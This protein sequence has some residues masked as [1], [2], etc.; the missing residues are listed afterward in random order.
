MMRSFLRILLVVV[1]AG[2]ILVVI[3]IGILLF[4]RTSGPHPPEQRM[5][6]DFQWMGSAL[7]TY[8]IIAGRYPTTEQGLKALVERSTF[9]PVPKDWEKVV[10]NVPTDP[11]R[12]EYQYRLVQD[13]PGAQFELRSLGPD[14]VDGTKDDFSS[15]GR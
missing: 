1:V 9:P 10:N 12:H 4:G 5:K 6:G 8:K 3:G 13:G 7:R 2:G 11:W 14:G 15:L